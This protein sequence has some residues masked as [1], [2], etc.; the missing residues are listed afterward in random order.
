MKVFFV[1][2]S[3]SNF[4]TNQQISIKLDGVL[5]PLFVDDAD[6]GVSVAF[7]FDDS[8]VVVVVVFL[9]RGTKPLPDSIQI[10]SHRWTSTY[11]I[12]K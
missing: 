9:L 11:K 8:F 1:R 7:Y 2:I 3:R 4:I 5:L 12:I 10:I 6:V